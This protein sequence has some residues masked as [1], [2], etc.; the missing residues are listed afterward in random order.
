MVMA[1]QLFT[2]KSTG[3]LVHVN[4][5]GQEFLEHGQGSEQGRRQGSK[6]NGLLRSLLGQRFYNSNFALSG[7]SPSTLTVTEILY[8]L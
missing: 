7:Y 8:L 5:T 2:W 6:W 4:E 3:P 1:F